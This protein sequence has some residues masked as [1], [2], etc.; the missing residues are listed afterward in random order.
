MIRKPSLSFD[1]P[2]DDVEENTS[3][4]FHHHGSEDV[5]CAPSNNDSA[6]PDYSTESAPPDYAKGNTLPMKRKPSLSSFM[7]PPTGGAPPDDISMRITLRRSQL[8]KSVLI[9]FSKLLKKSP[10]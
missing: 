2:P 6:P 7:M 9:C 1:A 10:V 3:P 8:L 5:I 4:M